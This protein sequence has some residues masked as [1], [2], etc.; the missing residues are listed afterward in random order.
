MFHVIVYLYLCF[1]YCFLD[2]TIAM[3][4]QIAITDPKLMAGEDL[5]VSVMNYFHFHFHYIKII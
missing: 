4:L 2:E 3:G 5:F 1:S